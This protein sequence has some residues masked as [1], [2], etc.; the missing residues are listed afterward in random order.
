M[1]IY[2]FN[3]KERSGKSD[4]SFRKAQG[5][6]AIHYIKIQDRLN[7]DLRIKRKHHPL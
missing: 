5:S 2:Y 6:L 1:N 3:S 4:S 7:G